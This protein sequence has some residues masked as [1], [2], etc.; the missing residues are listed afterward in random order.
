MAVIFGL[1][2]C[3]LFLAAYTSPPTGSDDQG[4]HQSVAHEA[5]IAFNM[6]MKYYTGSGGVHQSIHRA[7]GWFRK[8]AEMAHSRAQYMLG[9]AYEMGQGIEQDYAEAFKWYHRAAAKNDPDAQNGLAGLYAAGQGVEGNDTQAVK[10]YRKAAEKGV[11]N[12]QFE[13]GRHYMSGKGVEQDYESAYFWLGLAAI[14]G[15]DPRAMTKRDEAAEHLTEEQLQT[16]WQRLDEW[17]PTE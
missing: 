17:A 12:A 9:A 2:I 6:G 4:R 13:L 7:V 8:A 10:W 5:E 16:L 3:S 15:E 14:R 1:V 11:V